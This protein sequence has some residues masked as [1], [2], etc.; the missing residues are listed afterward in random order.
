MSDVDLTDT[1]LADIAEKFY[2]QNQSKVEIASE[3]GMSRFRVAR[4]LD[5]AKERGIVEI[6]VN[7]P[8]SKHRNLQQALAEHL[9][10][11]RTVIVDNDSNASNEGAALGLAAANYVQS[12]SQEG[13]N[14][15]LAWGRTLLPVAK[16]LKQLPP[17]TL[18]QMTG[19]IGSDITQS[20]LEV[21]SQ[22]RHHSDADTKA[23][24]APLF[25]HTPAAAKA[26]LSEPSVLDVMS[27]YEHLNTALLAVGSWDQ[28]VTQLDLHLSADECAELDRKKV[29]AD[30]CGL[31]F[32]ADGQ[33]VHSSLD[34]KR[35]SVAPGQLAATPVVV[36]V[37]TGM[38]KVG[39]LHSVARTGLVTC[40][41]TTA[42]VAEELL[43]LPAVE[44]PTWNRTQ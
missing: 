37:A 41:V 10:M 28:R 22:I 14:L 20:P 19:I 32:D 25:A 29:V 5:A 8:K 42:S 13:D 15:G 11:D 4:L 38:K 21:A 7:H 24:F 1:M 33:F 17:V 30:F 27:Y 6:T 43:K 40:L 34:R 36:A 26:L 3:F 9:H 44:N 18:V 39:A 2:L 31:F 16:N 35:I 12:I 23:L